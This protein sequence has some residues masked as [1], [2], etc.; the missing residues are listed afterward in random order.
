M[1]PIITEEAKAK[2]EENTNQIINIIKK[3]D[4]H[5]ERLAVASGVAS[6]IIE[7]ISQNKAEKIGMIEIIKQ[8]FHE[9]GMAERIIKA[10]IIQ[11]AEKDE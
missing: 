10:F 5:L 2:L 8:Y 11:E 3:I 9:E 4:D 6:Q 7:T 1:V